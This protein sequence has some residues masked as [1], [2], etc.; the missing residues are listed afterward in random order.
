M[1]PQQWMN[2]MLNRTFHHGCR[3][4]SNS[5]FMFSV[6][7]SVCLLLTEKVSSVGGKKDEH[8]ENT[9]EQVTKELM[10]FVMGEFPCCS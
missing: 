2:L 6:S 8:N 5:C 10:G 7:A 9:E 3:T 4:P 1:R